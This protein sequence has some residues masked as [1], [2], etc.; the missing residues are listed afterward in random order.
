[1]FN[2]KSSSQESSGL[3][4]FRQVAILL[5]FRAWSD[6]D[7]RKKEEKNHQKEEET[8]VIWNMWWCLEKERK[9]ELGQIFIRWLHH[10]SVEQ[11]NRWLCVNNWRFLHQLKKSM[12]KNYFRFF[13][14]FFFVPFNFWLGFK[15]IVSLRCCCCLCYKF[16]F[17]FQGSKGQAKNA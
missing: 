5:T 17:L 14:F 12:A 7:E 9:S 15:I 11:L 3:S 8:F 10:R 16:F 1:M 13:F 6:V 2:V 4:M